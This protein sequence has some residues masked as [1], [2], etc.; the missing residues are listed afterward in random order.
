MMLPSLSD[1]S[2]MVRLPWI[3]GLLVPF[4]F[5]KFIIEANNNNE[6]KEY[7]II[8]DIYGKSHDI[9]REGIQVIFTR[10]QFKMYKYFPNKFYVNDKIIK[11]GW[12]TY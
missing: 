7:G 10:S 8:V 9:I 6:G 2:M 4:E 3:K 1:K 5:D 11:Y 12:D